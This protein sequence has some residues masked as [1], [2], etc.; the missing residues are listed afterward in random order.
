MLNKDYKFYFAF[1]NSLCEDYV[2]EKLFNNMKQYIVPVVY[3][4]ADY[5]RFAP[6]HSY[7]NAN[8]FASAKDLAEYLLHLDK[9]PSEYIKYFWWKD[10]Y[11]ISSV[12]SFCHLCMKLHE[13]SF[14]TKTEVYGNI[15]EWWYGNQCNKI[16]F[17]QFR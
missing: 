17:I 15:K 1:E 10:H 14:A 7:I 2:T 16:P 8:D 11:E 3:G 6:P 4:G 12:S 5:N 13:P 9:N